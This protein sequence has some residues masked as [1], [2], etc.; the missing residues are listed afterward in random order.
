GNSPV[1]GASNP[2]LTLVEYSDFECPYCSKAANSLNALAKDYGKYVRFVFKHYPLSFHKKA[3]LA[4]QAAMA[5]HA[6]GK[7]WAYHDKLFA[8]QRKLDQANLERYAQEL[9]LQMMRFRSALRTKKYQAAVKAEMAQGAQVGVQGTP[10][11]FLEGK[12]LS[13]STYKDI[14]KA[15][16]KALVKKGIPRS[17]L[18]SL[19]QIPIEGAPA[20][21]AN[22]PLLTVVEFSDFE[23][24]FCSKAAKAL[25]YLAKDYKKYVRFVFKHYPLSFHKKAHLASQAA[26][27][28]HAQDKFWAYHDKLFAN[29]RQLERTD[30]ERYAQELNL[31]MKRFRKA[32]DSGKY[33]SA[34][35]QDMSAGTRFGVSGTP[36]FFVN[37]RRVSKATY[38]ALSRKLNRMLMAKGVPE[39]DLP[40]AI[41]PIEGSPAKGAKK[42]LVTVVEFSDFECPFCSKAAQSL[43]RLAK[44][45]GKEVR[46]V[47]KQYPLSFHKKA[48]LAAQAAMVAHA[49]GKFWAY[50][51]KLFANQ[52]QLGRADLERY[53]QEVGMNVV[54]LQQALDTQ[55]YK[56]AVDREMA[57]GDKFGVRGTP[58][59]FVQNRIVSSAK[60]EDLKKAIDDALLIARQQHQERSRAPTKKSDTKPKTPP[61]MRCAP[62]QKASQGQCIAPK[63][64]H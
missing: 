48:H 4:A 10:T 34:V 25:T 21:G 33:R 40:K 8:N 52:R 29:Q 56:D 24:P 3:E 51:D 60:Y 30:L 46:F 31:D 44:E 16:N 6:Q 14:A 17:K 57:Q 38:G 23:C 49:Q 15:L 55:M 36:S 28:A 5:A 59:F 12:R 9:G 7:F 62:G 2:L 63:A 45:Y 32:L 20:K 11:F 42:P 41:I 43:S 47:F 18:P 26:M 35:D 27:A 64:Q 1:K 39:A 22:K 61:Q 58:S 13:G 54:Y 53:A 19:T 50:H 37:N